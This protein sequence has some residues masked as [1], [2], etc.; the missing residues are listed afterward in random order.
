MAHDHSQVT[1]QPVGR[2][3]FPVHHVALVSSLS[4]ITEP[5]AAQLGQP[6]SQQPS[7]KAED[8]DVSY[9]SEIYLSG[10]M[11][12]SILEGEPAS[13]ILV[14]W[15]PGNGTASSNLDCYLWILSFTVF[16]MCLFCELVPQFVIWTLC[17]GKGASEDV[18]FEM[19]HLKR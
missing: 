2:F 15:Q 10:W 3:S 1:A 13:L 12:L 11:N 8:S 14:H 18:R 17:V 19:R 5:V 9:N 7:V 4:V 16:K 6:F